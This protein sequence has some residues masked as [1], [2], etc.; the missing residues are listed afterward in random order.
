VIRCSAFLI[1]C[2]CAPMSLATPTAQHGSL[3]KAI[4]EVRTP[5]KAILEVICEAGK[6]RMRECLKTKDYPG[7]KDCNVR[8]TSERIEGRF[9]GGDTAYLLAFYRSRCEPHARQ[10]GGGL[11]LE[12]HGDTLLFQ[13]YQP[14]LV[15]AECVTVTRGGGDRLVC[16][17]S[18]MDQAG[19]ETEMLGEV[20]FKKD[21]AGAIATSLDELL[22]A[23]RSESAR[24]ANAVECDEPAAYFSFADIT[25]GPMPE[26]IAFNTV[27]ADKP[28]IDKLCDRLEQNVR[29]GLA[30]LMENEAYIAPG[31]A[32]TGRFIYDLAKRAVVPSEAVPMR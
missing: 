25:R 26:T 30:P 9:L 7:G 3:D 6:I 14:G 16:I 2:L 20:V 1:A 12:K 28:L 27:Y 24:G 21:Q 8:L 15:V 23:R 32:K 5:D 4:L 31:Q 10:F 11:I 13:G 22:S 18:W 29:P 17:G 19:Y